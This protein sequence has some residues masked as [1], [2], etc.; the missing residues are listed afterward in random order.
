M[1]KVKAK[2]T[3]KD[4]IEPALMASIY[5]CSDSMHDEQSLNDRFDAFV[6]DTIDIKEFVKTNLLNEYIECLQG[7]IDEDGM[8]EG[9]LDST[10]SNLPIPLELVKDKLTYHKD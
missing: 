4:W 3:A 10:P 8:I 2:E 6:E 9:D 5:D 1:N 7:F